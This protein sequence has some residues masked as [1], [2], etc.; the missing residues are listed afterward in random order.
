MKQEE[1]ESKIHGMPEALQE[2]FRNSLEIST[3]KRIVNRFMNV[4]RQAYAEGLRAAIDNTEETSVR[5][6]ANG[7]K[8]GKEDI[9][10]ALR[11]IRGW[12][13]EDYETYLN[14]RVTSPGDRLYMALDQEADDLIKG[15]E[16]RRDASLFKKREHEEFA[17]K[18][19][20]DTIGIERLEE[21]VRGL[22]EESETPEPPLPF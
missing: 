17:V 16:K 20:A 4:V 8:D 14:I 2:T 19:M 21:I 3:A 6:Y 10:K 18:A 11:E 1:L 22:K 12:M 7:Y 13:Y 9:L 15:T 5:C